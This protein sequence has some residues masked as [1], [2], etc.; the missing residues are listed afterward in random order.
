MRNFDFTSKAPFTLLVIWVIAQKS[1]YN[2]KITLWSN[3]YLSIWVKAQKTFL[4][5]TRK[6]FKAQ[7]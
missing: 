1:K 3:A 5:Q 6:Y 7:K 4:K 2:Q